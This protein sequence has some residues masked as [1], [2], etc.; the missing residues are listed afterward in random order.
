[1][2]KLI[3]AISFLILINIIK[4]FSGC[5]PCDCNIAPGTFDFTQIK[6][7]NINNAG[8]WHS[9]TESDTLKAAAV[10]FKI[11][12]S[13]NDTLLSAYHISSFGF[14]QACAFECYC[15]IP[16]KPN[17]L[18]EDISIKTIY[19]LSDDMPAGSDITNFFVGYTDNY[20]N[21]SDK[22]YLSIDEILNKINPDM[23]YDTQT[24]SFQVYLKKE[25]TVQKAQ[26]L[27]SITLSDGRV[28]SDTTSLITIE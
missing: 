28:L 22:L 7:E 27:F 13:G 23:L 26:F 17:Q 19:D 21:T 4:L 10:A 8:R 20:S 15:P 3:N 12:V 25:I 1:M 5:G 16:F 24:V 14:S 2:K 18:I 9:I 11:S 6:T